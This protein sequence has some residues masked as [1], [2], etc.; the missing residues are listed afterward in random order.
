MIE[1]FSERA[2]KVLALANQEAQKFACEQVDTEHLLLTM[3]RVKDCLGS[4]LISRLLGTSD[5]SVIAS[6]HQELREKILRCSVKTDKSCSRPVSERVQGVLKEA[7]K[8]AEALQSMGVGTEHLLLGLLRQ[9]DSGAARSL[10]ARQIT[11]EQVLALLSQFDKGE[12]EASEASLSVS[13]ENKELAE[14]TLLE[15]VNQA[16][17][18]LG[19]GGPPENLIGRCYPVVVGKT[20]IILSFV[21]TN[22][23]EPVSAKE[24][25][26]ARR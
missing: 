8:E 21:H 12:G 1:R 7:V 13:P 6:L 5:Y 26:D 9:A 15:K 14:P 16:L 20:T 22:P 25:F 10:A 23:G 3:L 17:S 18:L 11:R 19:L 4:K 2:R 24:D